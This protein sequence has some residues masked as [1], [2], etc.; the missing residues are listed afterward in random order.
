VRISLEDWKKRPLIQKLKERFSFCL[1][2]R[3]DVFIARR[4]IA[5]RMRWRNRTGRQL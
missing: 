2:A 3:L 4:E 1:L 5:R